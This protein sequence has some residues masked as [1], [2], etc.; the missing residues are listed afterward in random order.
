MGAGQSTDTNESLCGW[1]VLK[2]QRNGPCDGLGLTPYFDIITHFNDIKLDDNEKALMQAI[3]PNQRLLLNVFSLSTRTSRTLSVTPHSG[4]G[5]DGLL[6]LM[7]RYDNVESSDFEC[8]HVL[9]VYPNSPAYH[10]GLQ[11]YSDWLLGTERLAFKGWDQL[12][13]WLGQSNNRVSTI[14]VF[15]SSTWRIRE[16]PIKPSSRWGGVGSLG[17]DL[18][19]GEKHRLPA[20][21]NP[22]RRPVTMDH[23]SE[24]RLSA[25]PQTSGLHR[26]DDQLMMHVNVDDIMMYIRIREPEEMAVRTLP[27]QLINLPNNPSNAN[28][29]HTNHDTHNHTSAHPINHPVNQSHQSPRQLNS[30]VPA[31]ASSVSTGVTSPVNQTINHYQPIPPPSHVSHQLASPVNPAGKRALQPKLPHSTPSSVDQSASHPINPTLPRPVEA[32]VTSGNHLKSTM[33]DFT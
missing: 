29:S 33:P 11:P 21:D 24:I 12:D 13:H 10:A 28:T 19:Q 30:I 5:G 31:L 6:G 23:R 9:N 22:A 20:F 26:E 14:C 3:Q 15:N 25:T 27:A 16:I 4:W 1:R 2:V 8:M 7:I 17:C 32:S 18:A